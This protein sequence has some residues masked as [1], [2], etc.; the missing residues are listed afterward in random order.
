MASADTG[1]YATDKGFGLGI[2]VGA[3]TGLAGKYYLATRSTTAID[4]GIGTYY[5]GYYDR[6]ALH[7]HGDFLWHPVALASTPSFQLP[8]Y[9]GVGARL[10]DH[11]EYY[12][13]GRWWAGATRLGVRVPFGIA[14]DFT[15]VPLDLF[16]ELVPVWD[17]VQN[18]H[19]DYGTYEGDRHDFDLT[20]ALGLRYYF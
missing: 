17:I 2:M 7:I 6:D 15:R 3:P 11:D 10:L 8:Y 9:I 18:Y 5:Y 16:V 13:D 14:F 20:G 4:F 12:R 1:S 19:D